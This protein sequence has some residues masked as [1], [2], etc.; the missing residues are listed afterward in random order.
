MEWIRID[1][2]PSVRRLR[3]LTARPEE[4]FA[5][6]E[7]TVAAIIREVQ[8]KGDEALRDYTEKFDGCRLEELRVTE[9]EI[10]DAAAAVGE[11]FLAVL[12]EA[13]GNIAAYHEMQKEQSWQKEF[14]PG[15]TLGALINPISRVGI[16]VPGGKAAYPSTVLMDTVPAQVAGVPSIVMV[17]PP[18]RDGRINPYILAAAKV[19]GITEIYKVGG[20]QAIAALAYGTETIDPVFKIVGPGNAF[21]AAA[22]R[23]VF[24]KVGI[25]MIAGPS[26]V[27]IIADES[28]NPRWVAADLLAQAEHDQRAAVYLVTPYEAVAEAIA[29]EVKQQMAQAPRREI[30]E[31]SIDNWMRIFVVPDLEIAFE[32]MNGLAPEHLELALENP[33]AYLDRVKNAGAVFLGHYTPEPIGDYFAGPNHTLPTSG[34]AAF[35]SPLGVYDYIKRSSVLEYSREAT[36]K[37]ARQVEMFAH[38]EGLFGHEASV[39]SRRETEK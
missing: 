28:V 4:T 24:G 8:S 5:G 38:A 12:K 27:G 39:R 37:V 25:D 21:V 7:E 33:R 14:R 30:M 19:L 32:V 2:K 26:E 16:Y 3:E 9:Q 18:G 10:S 34:T 15:V 1:A 22:K 6:V 17:T 23:Q 36:L 20:A 35:S 31:A 13:A 29:A 11:E